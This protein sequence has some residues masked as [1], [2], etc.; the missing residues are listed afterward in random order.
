MIRSRWRPWDS[1]AGIHSLSFGADGSILGALAAGSKEQSFHVNV[2][3][4]KIHPK[5]GLFSVE[6]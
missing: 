5:R 6:A 3:E 2:P 1:I 4:T